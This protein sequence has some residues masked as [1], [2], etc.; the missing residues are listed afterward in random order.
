MKLYLWISSYNPSEFIAWRS[1]A[2][3]SAYL[4]SARKLMFLRKVDAPVAGG[5]R[6]AADFS[7]SARSK[8]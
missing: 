7:A 2:G 5:G 3:L 6:T 4:V 1:G 8:D